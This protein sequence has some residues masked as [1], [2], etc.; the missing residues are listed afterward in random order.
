M[1][2]HPVVARQKTIDATVTLRRV[3]LVLIE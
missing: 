1:C 3:D 2:P